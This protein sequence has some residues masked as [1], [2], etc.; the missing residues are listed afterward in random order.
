MSQAVG[1]VKNIS[2]SAI[3]TSPSGEV[4]VLQVGDTLF[5]GDIVTNQTQDGAITISTLGGQEI[6][7]KGKEVLALDSSV[8][9]PDSFGN[10][11][12]VAAN[13]VEAIQQALLR[14]E[15]LDSLEETAAGTDAGAASAAGILNNATYIESGEESN[16]YADGRDIAIPDYE[17]PLNRPDVRVDDL[18]PLN[19]TPL[20][21]TISAPDN[22]KDTT[23]AI[24]GTTNAQAG[25]PIVITVADK[26]GN[27]QTAT[28]TAK[29]DGTFSI[30]VQN[31]LPD[32]VYTATATA[33]DSTGNTA[34]ATDPGSIIVD[35]TPPV[36]EPTPPPTTSRAN[37]FPSCSNT[38][39]RTSSNA[40]SGHNTTGCYYQC[41]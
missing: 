9:A 41:A 26:N 11:S 33:I 2:G 34:T 18:Q 19:T 30:D 25:T 16:V 40:P 5:M 17:L 32:G 20:V 38:T 24:I 22:T 21:V 6:T 37:P 15:K 36:I 3:A 28:T 27:I 8:I 31:P 1:I 39:S 13:S 12:N 29:V 35:T 23:P 7:I 4:R 10:E 14:G